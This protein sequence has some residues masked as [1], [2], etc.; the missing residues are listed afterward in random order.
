MDIP[1]HPGRSDRL[2]VWPESSHQRTMTRDRLVTIS[3]VRREVV[4][5][6]VENDMVG[7]A[8]RDGREFAS[9]VAEA[10]SGE[11]V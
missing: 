3:D 7:D 8:P 4:W 1:A 9:M 11:T 10:V 6:M 2:P 5:S